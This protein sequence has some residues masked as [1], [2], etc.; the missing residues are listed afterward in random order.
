MCCECAAA[1]Q[2]RCWNHHQKEAAP[3]GCSLGRRDASCPFRRHKVRAGPLQAD[4]LLLPP[5]WQA[6]F[7]SGKTAGTP[8]PTR[9]HH[10]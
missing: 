8:A 5:L 4:C 3:E 10:G 9:T 1:L 6:T 2:S 7:A